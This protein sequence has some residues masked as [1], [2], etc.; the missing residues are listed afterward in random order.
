MPVHETDRSYH[1]D[2]QMQSQ[3]LQMTQGQK[4]WVL[5]IK[6]RTFGRETNVPNLAISSVPNVRAINSM[7]LKTCL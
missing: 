3:S 6:P 7:S 4:M 5:G 2:S 1:C